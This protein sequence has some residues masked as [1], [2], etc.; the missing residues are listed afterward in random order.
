MAHAH[1]HGGDA[2]AAGVGAPR[3]EPPFTFLDMPCD[4]LTVLG[5]VASTSGYERDMDGLQRLCRTARDDTMLGAATADLRYSA[6]YAGLTRSRLQYACRTNDEAR[7]AWLLECG[8]RD[9]L[10]CATWGYKG[11]PALVRRMA[12]DPVVDATHAL[13]AAAHLGVAELVAPLVAR[14]AQLEELVTCDSGKKLTALQTATRRGNLETVAALLAAGADVNAAR[15]HSHTALHIAVCRGLEFV[16]ALVAAGADVNRR[17]WKGVSAAVEALGPEGEGAPVAAYLCALPQADPSAHIA[18]AIWLGDVALVRDFIARG[19]SVEERDA[20]GRTCLMLAVKRGHLEIVRALLDAGADD[21]A[22]VDGFRHNSALYYGADKP[23]ILALLLKRFEVGGDAMR[24]RY[25]DDAL[26]RAVETRPPA[27]MACVRMLLGAGADASARVRYYQEDML[28]GSWSCSAR[29][30]S[31]LS[32]AA[33]AGNVAAFR[34]LLAAGADVAGLDQKATAQ[35][36]VEAGPW[37]REVVPALLAA[38]ADAAAGGA[39]GAAAGP[40]A[41]AGGG[42][43]GGGEAAA[44]AGGDAAAR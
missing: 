21:V 15:N 12:A 34:V 24:Q 13:V 37:E 28:F 16:T 25:L 31:A 35:E 23:A 22:P 38:V 17:D 36:E 9:V 27:G 11:G 33:Q 40:G 44:G 29:R 6:R 5:P 39:G 2:A 7:V 10:A 26:G 30:Y 42:G 3:P 4:L 43:G 20:D 19:A 8:A 32:W 18:A 14:G 41:G 1:A